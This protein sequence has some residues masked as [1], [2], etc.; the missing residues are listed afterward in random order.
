MLVSTTSTPSGL[1]APNAS[2]VSKPDQINSINDLL[3]H[4]AETIPNTPLIAYPASEHSSS[5]LAEYTAKDLDAFVD[6][7]AKEYTRLGLLPK[8]RSPSIQN[9]HQLLTHNHRNPAAQPAKS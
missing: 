1:D 8:V 4:K 5:D 7:A 9:N 3:L 2:K 6:E